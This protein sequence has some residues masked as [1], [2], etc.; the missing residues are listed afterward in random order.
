M[1]DLCFQVAQKFCNYTAEMWNSA[2]YG[3]LKTCL[4]NF[5]P[6]KLSDI[7]SV[8]GKMEIGILKIKV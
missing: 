4:M 7:D 8:R 1:S 3:A 6:I 2:N 5:D